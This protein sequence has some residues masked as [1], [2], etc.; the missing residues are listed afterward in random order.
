MALW[1]FLAQLY[2]HGRVQVSEPEAGED[3]EDKATE[4]ILKEMDRLSR[5][6]MAFEAPRLDLAAARWAAETLY[7]CCQ[8]L[9]FGPMS[10]QAMQRE[11]ARPCPAALG[12]EVSYSVDLTLRYLP[13]IL[14]LVR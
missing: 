9:A 2:E 7:R 1:S 3:A 12:P 6:E 11:L 4:E 10:T 5:L 14:L 8:F 13:D